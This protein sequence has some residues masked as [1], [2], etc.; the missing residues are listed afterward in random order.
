MAQLVYLDEVEHDPNSVVTV[1]TFDGVHKGHRA[2]MDRVLQKADEH[3]ARSVIV[4]FDP[5]PRDIINPGESGIKLLTTLD[6]RC[7]RL[8]SLGIDLMVVIP[9]DRDFSLITSE[10]FVRDIMYEKIGVKEFVIGYD[11]KF[12]RNRKGTIE[13]IEEL[14]E[15]LG[16]KSY[17]V[18]K[19]EYGDHTISSTAI[20]KALIEDGDVEFASDL[21]GWT[22]T[23]SGTVIHGDKRGKKIGF[24]TANL[25]PEHPHKAIPKDGVYAVRVHLKNNEKAWGGMMNIGS[26]PT[27]EGQNERILEVHLFDFDDEIYGKTLQLQFAKRI[28]DEMKFDGVDELVAQ[29]K[30]DEKT[31][32]KILG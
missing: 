31:A 1:G 9:F 3:D 8:D 24:P 25:K 7:K 10:E 27:F 22:Y 26:R 6:E 21:L 2:I 29:L 20:R 19:K 14:G 16:F 15:E 30:R 4:T 28:R 17:V 23:L 13:T 5:H 12:G 18:S 11:H 32:R